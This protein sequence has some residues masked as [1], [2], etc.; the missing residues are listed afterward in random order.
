MFAWD[1][2]ELNSEQAAA[3][4]EPLSAFLVACPGSGKT[5]TLTYKI[6]YE[7]SRSAD[8]RIVAAITYTHRAADEIQERIEDL[9]VDT[10]NLWIGTIHSF[11]LEW[12]IKPYGIY[13]P[14]LARG[15][16]V[17]DK[18]DREL[19]LERL[20]AP[21]SGITHWDCDYYF[22]ETGYLLSCIDTWK[23]PALHKV[24]AE[25]FRELAEAR[26]IDFELI[27]WHANTLMQGQKHIASLLSQVFSYILVDE[28]Q[29]TKQIQYSLLTAILRAGAGRTK[30]FIVGDPNQAIYGSL[31][32]YAIPAADFRAHS[33]IPIKEMALSRNYR[34]SQ[35]IIT[36]FSNF[37]VHATSIASAGPNASFPSKVTYNR[38]VTH[39]DVHEELVRLIQVSLAAGH[40]PEEICVIAPW[41]IL[42][43]STTR[44]LVTMLPDQQF[45]GPGLVPFSNDFDNFWFK[46]S[47]ILLTESSPKM[48]I[49]RMRWAKDVINDLG[50]F[51]ADISR[52]TQRLL[53]REC[54]SISIT[55][56]DGIAY[57]DQA[58]AALF[59]QLDIA[60]E[61]FPPLVEHRDAFF[62]SSQ[63]RIDRLQKAGAPYIND[64]SFFRKVFRERT[65]ITVSTIHGVKGAE[66]DVVIAFGLLQGMVPH[67]TE[68]AS[69]DA[70]SKLLYVVGSRA[71][72]HLHLIS[73]SGR[74]QGRNR[75]YEA[76]EALSRCVF[77]YDAS[78]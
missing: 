43:A 4:T 19:M 38:Q 6:A 16:R 10:S 65:G 32:G 42:L 39:T 67:F 74:P 61:S 37:N 3:V 20:C 49:R 17:L 8:K 70:A 7:L 26:Q 69:L 72:K 15:Y 63:T 23:H 41:W 34:S 62:R 68:A 50:A 40:P 46:L 18:H 53:L 14:E 2:R 52:L 24:L 60:I 51:G 13:L 64:I 76:T 5:R 22:N 66:F 21:Y 71:R 28:Y 57:L 29:D 45:D 44:Q 48:L 54:N 73:E 47:K 25:Y 35:R 27:L 9:G 1:A 55:E 30:T 78:S 31:G 59:E 77:D 56:T 11:C 58:F 36:H 33:G 12:I 75:Q